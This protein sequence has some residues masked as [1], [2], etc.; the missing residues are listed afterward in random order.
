M[1]THT[2]ELSIEPPSEKRLC[3]LSGKHS[4]KSEPAARKLR[5]ASFL[6]AKSALV[7]EKVNLHAREARLPCRHAASSYSFLTL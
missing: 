2:C 7:S 6:E 5:A 4:F 1:E 3:N